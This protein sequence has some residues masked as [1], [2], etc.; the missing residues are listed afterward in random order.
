MKGIKRR[1]LQWVVLFFLIKKTLG[2]ILLAIVFHF[3]LDRVTSE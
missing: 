3:G 1:D 2:I